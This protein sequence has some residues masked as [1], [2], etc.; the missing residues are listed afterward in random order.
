MWNIGNIVRKIFI[1]CA[2]GILGLI[3]AACANNLQMGYYSTLEPEYRFNVNAPVVLWHD[4]GDLVSA[5]YVDLIIYE[6]QTRGFNSVYKQSEI[7]D[8]TARNLVHFRLY[9]DIR[10]DPVVNY[11]YSVINDG[12]ISSCYFYGD[13]F[14]CDNNPQKAFNV[15]DFS[16][17][18]Q[19]VTTY[20]FLMNWYD[21][22]T[23]KRIMIVD[24][25]V[26]GNVCGYNYVFRDLIY[27]TIAR[28][29]FTRKEQYSYES[30]LPAYWVCQ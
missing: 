7:S 2:Y 4:P 22:N 14:Y 9:K 29:D 8:K 21:I 19:Y 1:I 6:L 13:K 12:V 18:V 23:K 17:S 28:L 5:Y 15:T 3:F 27:N 20:H 25:S 16:Q 26:R 30:P 10:A 11:N 24:G